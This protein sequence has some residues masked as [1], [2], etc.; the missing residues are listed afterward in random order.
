MLP[1]RR[2]SLFCLQPNRKRQLFTSSSRQGLKTTSLQIRDNTVNTRGAYFQLGKNNRKALRVSFKSSKKNS[3]HVELGYCWHVGR[4][5]KPSKQSVA[6]ILA[7][8]PREIVALPFTERGC[9]PSEGPGQRETQVWAAAFFIGRLVTCCTVWPPG[10]FL[11]LPL[12]VEDPREAGPLHLTLFL[13]C[14]DPISH[15]SHVKCK[16]N[17]LQS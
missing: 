2:N 17:K 11:F 9:R 10:A 13:S 1:L 12:L 8:C 15:D 14:L 7:L 4:L 16:T 3:E 6:W 5:S